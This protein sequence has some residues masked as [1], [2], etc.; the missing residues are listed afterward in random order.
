MSIAVPLVWV[1]TIPFAFKMGS[2]HFCLLVSLEERTK[3]PMAAALGLAQ[4]MRTQALRRE[5]SN[6]API[7]A[8][9][10]ILFCFAVV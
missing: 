10:A 1:C 3:N 8:V 7:E 9:G 5:S 4:V 6:I 2:N